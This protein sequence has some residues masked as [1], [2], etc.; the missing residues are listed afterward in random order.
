[1][2]VFLS[3]AIVDKDLII[4]LKIR[5]SK[6]GLQLL[7][8]EHSIG[9]NKTITEK[10]ELMIRDSAV[11]LF[12]LTANGDESK[13]VQ[14]EIG[15]VQSIKKPALY[16]VQKGKQVTGFAY[17]RD[18]IELDPENPDEAIKKALNRLLLHWEKLKEIEIQERKNA[19]LFI[20]ALVAF[21]LI[22]E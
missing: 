14:Q 9:L 2:K 19:G 10:I 20:A 1:M 5:C 22:A 18:Y 13:F 11:A 7:I 21:A 17:G 16:I 4:A 15:Y 8:A 12:L 3:H 6:N